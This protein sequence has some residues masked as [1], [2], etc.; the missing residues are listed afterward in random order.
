MRY[1][2][3]DPGQVPFDSNEIT[4]VQE[5]APDS[6]FRPETA[7]KSGAKD[8]LVFPAVGS[9]PGAGWKMRIFVFP[10]QWIR[11]VCKLQARIFVECVNL[12]PVPPESR[13]EAKHGPRETL[14]PVASGV[15][16]S[17]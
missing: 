12:A 17:G 5:W 15:T 2:S 8:A 7:F 10:L 3:G 16:V 9:G 6:R 14:M 1:R 4:I 11:L 13:G